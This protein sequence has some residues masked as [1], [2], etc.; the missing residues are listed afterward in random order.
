MSRALPF[1]LCALVFCQGTSASAATVDV[2][3][4]GTDGR[5]AARAVVELFPEE[6]AGVLPPSLLLREALIDQRDEMFIP[7]VTILRRGGRVQFRNSDSTMHQVYSFSEIKQFSLEIDRGR[8][9]APVVFD[10]PGVAAIGCN[11]HDHMVTFVYVAATPWATSADANGRAKLDGVPPGRYRVSVWDPQI[12]PG[13]HPQA[14]FLDVT[15]AGA[16]LALAIP[17]LPVRHRGTRHS[18]G[19]NY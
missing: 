12:V 13:H 3:V 9:S 8:T 19:R 16:R 17:L 14:A 2:A 5:A 4:T 6:R 7:L 11:I 10:K 15:D 18:Q 1:G